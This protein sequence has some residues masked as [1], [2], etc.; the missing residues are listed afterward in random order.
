MLVNQHQQFTTLNS[1]RCARPAKA[2]AIKAAE[3]KLRVLGQKLRDLEKLIEE[4]VDLQKKRIT[5]LKQDKRDLE[6]QLCHYGGHAGA[7][8][9]ALSSRR[10]QQLVGASATSPAPSRLAA[11]LA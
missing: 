2:A 3:Q 10:M 5:H 1:N 6:R 7:L 9:A 11:A 4:E 8:A